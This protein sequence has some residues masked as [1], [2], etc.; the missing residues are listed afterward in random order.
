ML[1]CAPPGQR[2]EL[3]GD[4]YYLRLLL[5]APTDVRPF[6]AAGTQRERVVKGCVIDARS[7]RRRLVGRGEIYTVQFARRDRSP[8][9]RRSFPVHFMRAL[10]RA[11]VTRQ[12]NQ[13][14]EIESNGLVGR[15][16]T[17]SS[18]PRETRARHAKRR[19]NSPPEPR[20]VE[21][22]LGEAAS[23]SSQS[24]RRLMGPRFYCLP[25]AR[26]LCLPAAP[27]SLV[28]GNVAGTISAG[29]PQNSRFLPA[30]R[31]ADRRIDRS[32]ERERGVSA[33]KS[34]PG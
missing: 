4:Y 21:R 5:C 17:V 3:L 18:R 2:N 29:G 27:E 6:V 12:R 8:G 24:G 28:R 30:R 11:A 9:R 13:P 32:A 14:G 20:S 19:R 1:S 31:A 33:V 22:E 26:P 15:C 7:L 16:F 34:C 25:L 10:A 23:G